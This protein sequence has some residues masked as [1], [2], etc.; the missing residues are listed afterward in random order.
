MPKAV[1]FSYLLS[2]TRFFFQK[3][4]LQGIKEVT[5]EMASIGG[6]VLIN[7]AFASCTDNFEKGHNFST[8]L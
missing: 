5:C 7:F 1:A 2:L 6:R 4:L 8:E 3:P